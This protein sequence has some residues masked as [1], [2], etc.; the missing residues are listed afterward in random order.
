MSEYYHYGQPSEE[1]V[2]LNAPSNSAALAG[3]SPIELQAA[4]NKDRETAAKQKL[5]SDTSLLKVETIDEFI[6]TRDNSKIPAR[7]Y[8]PGDRAPDES[9]PV[10]VF[11][12][13]GGFIFGT[14]DSESYTCARIVS[15]RRVVLIHICYRHPPTYQYP[16]QINDAWD[17]FEWTVSHAERLGGD[18]TRLILG[19]ISAGAALAASVVLRENQ[20]HPG[21]GRIVGQLLGIPWL[22]HPDAWTS[23]MET[24]Q[25]SYAQNKD[26]PILTLG[27]ARL[28][29]A[30]LNVADIN[31][32]IQFVGNAKDS[33][34]K[35]MPRTVMLVAGMDLLR[36]EALDYEKRLKEQAVETKC[37]VFSGLPHGFYRHLELSATDEWFKSIADGIA[38]ISSHE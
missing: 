10:L 7:V 35:G 21:N 34:L 6:S 29:A 2:K 3:L 15:E 27:L 12:H 19:G 37:H 17:A 23:R 1:W 24:E 20:S 33:D 26:A 30:Q 14:I 25:C 4:V 13:G 8:R 9:L 11:F 22:L 36:D 18:N 28:F 31:D 38:W 32:E 5:Q 16:T